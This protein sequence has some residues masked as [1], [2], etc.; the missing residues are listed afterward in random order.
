MESNEM[1][2]KNKGES[3]LNLQ[4]LFSLQKQLDDRIMKEH[5]LTGQNVVA[6]KMLA[7][8]VELGELANETRCFKYWSVK[9]P[10]PQDVILEEYVDGIH[11][12]LSI[13]LDCG[14]TSVNVQMEATKTQI[15]TLFQQVF[16]DIT[17]FNQSQ[18]QETYKQLFQTYLQLGQ[19]LGFSEKNI[20]KA[21]LQKNEVNHQR[22]DE[23]Y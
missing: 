8:Q 2:K 3:Q 5:H 4:S 23:G 15:V 17:K 11:F 20:E 13:G 6:E 16:D 21:Y 7:L 10:A 9:P 1:I 22:Q 14:Y 19:A 18:S 12:I